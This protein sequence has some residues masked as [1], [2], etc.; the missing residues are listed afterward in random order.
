MN[1]WTAEAKVAPDDCA[2]LKLGC[3]LFPLTASP[4]HVETPWL[5]CY[6]PCVCARVRTLFF[7]YG[8]KR[9]LLDHSPQEMWVNIYP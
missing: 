4:L 5:A 9:D 2:W 8:M 3:G 6:S 1:S 7:L